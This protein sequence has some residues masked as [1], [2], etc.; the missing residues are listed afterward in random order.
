MHKNTE[1]PNILINYYATRKKFSYGSNCSWS[2]CTN[3]KRNNSLK[4]MA[5]ECYS[6]NPRNNN[7]RRVTKKIDVLVEKSKEQP[8]NIDDYHTD[9]EELTRETRISPQ[10]KTPV[11]DTTKMPRL[12]RYCHHRL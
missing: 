5:N 1:L 12:K 9:E 11:T 4:R 3:V 2:Y 6:I 7:N 8:P 10:K